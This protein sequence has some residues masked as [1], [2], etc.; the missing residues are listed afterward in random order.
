MIHKPCTVSGGGKSEISKP[1]QNALLYGPF[2]TAN[3]EKDMQQVEAI[4]NRNYSD[5]FRDHHND[6]KSSRPIMSEQRSLGSVIK[7]LTPSPQYSDAYNE[8]VES[9]PDYIRALVFIIKRFHKPDWGDDWRSKF[10]V[11]IMNGWP[12]H[13]LKYEGRKLVAEYMRIGYSDA[14]TWRTFKL[15]QDFRPARKISM[16][17]DISASIVVPKEKLENLNEHL[18]NDSLKILQNCEYRFFQRP[19]EAVHPG[20][21]PHAEADMSQSDNLLANYEPLQADDAR[22]IYEDVMSYR[23]FTK[24]MQRI[25]RRAMKRGDDAFFSCN[26]F[27]RIVD[28]KPTKNPRYLQLRPDLQDSRDS[29]LADMTLRMARHIPLNEP[30]QWPVNAV[31]PGRRNN[32]ADREAGIRA[33]SVYNPIHYQELPELFMDFVCSLSGKSPSTTGAGSEGALTKAPFNALCPVTDLNNALLSYILTGYNGYSSPAGHIG[34]Q[35]VDH[36]VSFIIPELWCRMSPEDRDPNK[37]IAEGSLEKIEDFEHDGVLVKASRL[38]YRIT[39]KFVHLYLGKMFDSPHAAFD[40]T[41]LKPESTDKEGFIDGIQNIVEAQAKVAQLYF[42][43]GSIE[44]ACPPLKAILY[45]M[46]HGEYEGKDINDPAIR[47]LF[48]IENVLHS[49]WYNERLDLF[50]EKQIK[51]WQNH[52]SYLESF[53]KQYAGTGIVEED[54]IKA[55]KAL[56][57][58]KLKEVKSKAFRKSLVGSIG[59]DPLA[60]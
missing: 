50:Q 24:P 28:G 60:R 55:K 3:L 21:D 10:G 9:I 32:P 56:A 46:V 6:P 18:D 33:L 36:D 54:S 13:E 22:N 17:D 23:N 41:L 20:G 51:L 43:D 38:G 35:Q 57:A 30:V 29:Y 53:E 2:Y 34:R 37:L 27:P 58:A 44:F 1:L 26:A 15:R 5:R 12:G 47:D 8:W 25:I 16:E 19:D 7:L 49:D 31:V 42:D 52:I 59:A 40:E 14:H 11:D 4:I 48:K 39:Q 45:I